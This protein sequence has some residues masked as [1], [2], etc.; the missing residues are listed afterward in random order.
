MCASRSRRR[1]LQP[2]RRTKISRTHRSQPFPPDRSCGLSQSSGLLYVAFDG[3]ES[4]LISRAPQL[5]G[6]PRHWE[7]CECPRI[8]PRNGESESKSRRTEPAPTTAGSRGPCRRRRLRPPIFASHPGTYLVNRRAHSMSSGCPD[9][10]SSAPD[11]RPGV[12]R[13][14]A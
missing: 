9:P 14:S 5:R 6:Q 4:E 8:D 12:G 10:G 13:S 2:R 11:C 3:V 7:R 1:R